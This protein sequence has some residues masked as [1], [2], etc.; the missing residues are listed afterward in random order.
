MADFTSINFQVN[1]GSVETPN[2]V[3]I[4]GGS[5]EI[6][7]SDVNTVPLTTPSASW[8][9]VSQPPS[10]NTL[11]Y[12][13]AFTSDVS[14]LLLP[15]TDIS[16]RFFFMAR[17]TWDN[18]GTFASAP[19][20]TAYPSSSHGSIT[21]GDGSVL[22]GHTSDTGATARSYLK[23]NAWG[24]VSSAGAPTVGP[25]SAVPTGTDGTTGSVS[26]TAGAH[27][28]SNWQGLQ[29]DNDYITAPF[30]PAPT[31]S[32]SWPVLFQLLVG[33][34]EDVGAMTF[35]FALKYSYL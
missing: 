28:L 3:N 12:A 25:G 18:I 4:S 20:F 33:A 9:G 24:R 1:T 27:W 6:R 32:D 31:T 11:T 2:W 35:V 29:G 34:N 10:G 22:G 7:F 17:W 23:G 13:Y 16:T 19:I 21:R 30:T 14:G 5:Q 15:L 26:P 8:P